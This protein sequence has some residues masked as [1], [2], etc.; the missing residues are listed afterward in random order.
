MS[1]N[2]TFPPLTWVKPKNY[3]S[4]EKG[5][6]I[7]FNL[8]LASQPVLCDFQNY[9]DEDLAETSKGEKRLNNSFFIY[10]SA[11]LKKLACFDIKMQDKN[12]IASHFWKNVATPQI[13]TECRRLY[14]RAKEMR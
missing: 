4:A 5:G 6:K 1:N 3:G 13:R 2:S 14:Q 11:M 10:K 8:Y 9:T 7:Q 12:K